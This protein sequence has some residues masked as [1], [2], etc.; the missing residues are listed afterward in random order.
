MKTANFTVEECIER[1]SCRVDGK[2]VLRSKQSLFVLLVSLLIHRAYELGY[3]LTFGDA[4]ADDGHMDRSLHYIRLAI[5][6]NLFRDG[7]YL[8]SVKAHQ[9]LGEYWESLGGSWGGRF[10]DA[11]HYSLEHHGRK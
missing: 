1:L 7:K 4:M 5:D 11:N 3:E 2:G 6:L 8:R 10:N 9:E